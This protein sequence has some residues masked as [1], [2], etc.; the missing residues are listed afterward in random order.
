M[1]KK[2]NQISVVIAICVLAFAFTG[3]CSVGTTVKR[4]ALF[5]N[6]LGYFS[7]QA[8]L[9]ADTTT[10][11]IGQLP[12][13]SLGTFWVHYPQDVV[14]SRV[15]TSLED[16]QETN[17]V[18][19]IAW[20]L[21][22]NVGR[23]AT[24]MTSTKDMAAM[25][26]VIVS[27]D[28]GSRMVEQP[29]PY[30]MDIRRMDRNR[31]QPYPTG[32]LLVLK[33]ERGTVAVNMNSIIRVDI[34]GGGAKTNAIRTVK[35]P[36][37]RLELEKPAGGKEVSLHWLAR[38]I[39]WAP[40]YLIDLSAET[41]AVLS[42][43]AVILNEVE[44]LDDV[45]LELVSGFP[46]IGFSDINSPIALSQT[47]ADYL[48]ALT[49]GRS[50]TRGRNSYMMQQQAAMSN[51]AMYDDYA[52][53]PMPAYSTA[54]EGTT[55]EDLYFYPIDKFSLKR[56]ETAMIPLF[57]AEVPYIHIYTWEIEDILDNNDRYNRNR[58]QNTRPEAEIVWHCCRMWNTMNMPWTTAPA[59]FI[60]DGRFT[61]Q[62]TC[63][64]TAPGAKATIRINRAMNVVA[65]EAEFEVTRTRNASRF[66]GS[67]YDLVTVKGEL[68]VRNRQRKQ[69]KMEITKHLSGTVK[70]MAPEA[71]DVPTVKGLKKVNTRHDLIWEISLKPDEEV[72][73]VYTYDVY[74]RN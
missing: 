70:E 49:S 45:T 52:G 22:A 24:V 56:N 68:K 29:S 36:A 35:Q 9:P 60:K 3:W 27:A 66:Y 63:Y 51:F 7:A 18:S 65:E 13:P 17:P 44:D 12:V 20:L 14:L 74:V 64:Y 19:S 15:V 67:S 31:Y 23:K 37:I 53:I 28:I 62:D 69:V 5:K 11:S 73:L 61:G 47:L 25:E 2:T 50:E 54:Q 38:G 40:S 1:M 72:K 10:V 8:V 59:E 42:A 34:E 4:V 33:T 6:G 46:N 30:R 55:A 57:S 32:Q 41:T 58:N 48:K 16:V 71:K 39:T 21:S 43:K 26:G